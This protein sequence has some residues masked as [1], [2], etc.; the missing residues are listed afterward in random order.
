MVLVSSAETNGGGQVLKLTRRHGWFGV[1]SAVKRLVRYVPWYNP[2]MRYAV[3]ALPFVPWLRRMP[4]VPVDVEVRLAE[5]SVFMVKPDRCEIAKQLYWTAGVREPAEDAVALAL[6]ERLCREA[7]VAMDIGCNSGLFAMAAARANPGCR[8]LAFDLLPEAIEICFANLVRNNLVAQVEPCLRGIGEPGGRFRVPAR[9][10]GATMPSSVSTDF[11]FDQGVEV[12]IVS[13]DS[14]AD[15]LGEASRVAIKIDVE[16][17]EHNLFSHG[18]AFLA[19]YRPTI[20]CE[21]LKRAKVEAYGPMLAGL[22]YHFALITDT[23][24][25]PRDSLVP[26]PR[27]KDWL[28]SPVPFPAD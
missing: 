18:Q 28:F 27:Y 6:F 19:R 5:G 12:P 3:S 24:L 8:V 9:V 25:V 2:V 20:V 10:G 4:V 11:A 17:T 1:K 14:L 15:S 23:G 13:L 16:A 21:V 22:G 26:H 7:D